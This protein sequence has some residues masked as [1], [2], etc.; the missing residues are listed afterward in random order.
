M[1]TQ[2][3]EETVKATDSRYSIEEIIKNHPDGQIV[4][5]KGHVPW[6]DGFR[7]V[8]WRPDGQCFSPKGKRLPQFDL[9]FR[10]VKVED[11][12]FKFETEEIQQYIM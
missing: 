12:D 3:I 11:E 6:G 2:E 7:S 8:V 9:I 10:T 5:V 4:R 1:T